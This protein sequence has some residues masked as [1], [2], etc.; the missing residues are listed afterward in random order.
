MKTVRL[1]ENEL[2][3]LVKR[4]V[5]EKGSEGHFMDYH[6]SSKSTTGKEGMAMIL[7]IMDNLKR[8][9]SRLESSNFCHSR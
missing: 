4:I 1:N 9:K 2:T 6:R 7:K 3:N 8:M 5:E